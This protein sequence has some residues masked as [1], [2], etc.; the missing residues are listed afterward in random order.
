M[1]GGATGATIGWPCRT[2]RARG[3][4]KAVM[5]SRIGVGMDALHR[6]GVVAEMSTT[7]PATDTIDPIISVVL[8]LGGID[9]ND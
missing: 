3:T 5:G 6:G 9:Q 8:I 2:D 7:F 4:T 1:D